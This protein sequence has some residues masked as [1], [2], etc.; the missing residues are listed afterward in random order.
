MVNLI[1]SLVLGAG[2]DSLYYF[3]YI[4]KIKEIGK[5]K[6]LLYFGIFTVYIITN[7]INQYN[8]KLYLLFDILIY[9][10]LKFKYKGKIND[11][12]LLIFI[13]SYMLLVSIICFFLIENYVIALILAKICMFSPLILKNKLK[14]LYRFNYI[15]WDRNRE[16]KM[17][18]KSLTLRNICITTFNVFI[19]INY[20]ILLILIKK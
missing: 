9:L 13:D 12:F 6:L 18:I 19:V 14:R 7:M 17:P 2:I 5:K 11:F 16:Y 1:L 10:L 20:V 3:L 8:F 4:S 15:M